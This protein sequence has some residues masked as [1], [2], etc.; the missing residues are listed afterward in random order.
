MA[1]YLPEDS[2]RDKRS[3][4]FLWQEVLW[5]VWGSMSVEKSEKLIKQAPEEDSDRDK[6]SLEFLWQ[7]VLWGVWGSMSVEKSEKL[8]KQAPEHLRHIYRQVLEES[9]ERD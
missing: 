8:I 7:E 1:D 6:R 5:G 9:Y 3:L 2:D 4:E